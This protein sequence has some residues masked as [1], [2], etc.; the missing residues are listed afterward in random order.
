MF[1]FAVKIVL[2][3]R[4]SPFFRAAQRTLVMLMP[5]AVI[6]AYFKLLNDLFFSPDGMIYNILGLDKVMSDH[7]WYAGSFV[8]KGMVGI[9]FGVFGVYASYFMARYTARIYRKDSTLA[10]LMAVLILLFCSYASSSGRNAGLPFTASLL[11][12]KALFLALIVGY[13]VGQVF[14]WLGKDYQP[15]AEENVKWVQQRAWDAVWPSL[16][17]LVLGIV[18]GIA[19]Y[20]LQLKMLN[21]ASFKEI[22]GRIQ[23]SNNLVEVLLLLVI[24]TFLNWLG[25]GFPMSSVTDR[26]NNSFTAANLTYALQHGNS[27]H[28]PYK[29]LGSS[30]VNSYGV[31]GGTSVVLAIIVLLLLRRSG[32]E[33]RAIARLNLLPATFSCGSGFAIGLPVILNPVFLLPSVLLP[34]VNVILAACALGLHLIPACVYP[35]LKGT[36]G[37]LIP[38]LATNGNWAALVFS[39]LLFFLDLLLLW[40]IIKINEKVELQ[41]VHLKE[42]E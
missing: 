14:H 20:E 17:S 16:V 12:I 32:R 22:V 39:I 21:S 36:P 6:G 31:M 29:F 19:I 11:Q 10:G 37:L 30:L 15:V 4:R 23:T 3:I 41:I 34:L 5:I 33:I 13:C 35:I 38:F 9:T 27:W 40:P 26:V 42:V 25:I 18:L 24:I 2:E 1:D 28:V 8:S 7:I